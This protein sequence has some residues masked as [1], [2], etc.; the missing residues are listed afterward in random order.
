M[1]K[2]YD[3]LAAAR[4][5]IFGCSAANNPVAAASAGI[6]VSPG[7]PSVLADAIAEMACLSPEVRN[8]MGLAGRAYVERE[9]NSERLARRLACVL[10]SCL[11]GGSSS[12]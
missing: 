12:K 1:N 3:Y 10:N 5:V 11:L 7:N 8:R 9:H 2:I 6:V 4:P